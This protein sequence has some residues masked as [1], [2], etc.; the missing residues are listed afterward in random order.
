MLLE[1]PVVDVVVGRGGDTADP[2]RV[3]AYAL[4]DP[5]LCAHALEP[6]PEVARADG[7]DLARELGRQALEA[8]SPAREQPA[9]GAAAAP[10]PKLVQRTLIRRSTNWQKRH[11]PG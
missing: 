2:A 6:V 8:M 1:Q 5:G 3:Q 11:R 4:V 7:L 9:P 10:G